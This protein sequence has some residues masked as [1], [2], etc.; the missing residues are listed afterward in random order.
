MLSNQALGVYQRVL[1]LD[2][3]AENSG[4]CK[5]HNLQVMLISLLHRS[6]LKSSCPW[7]LLEHRPLL[8]AWL[9][10]GK[11]WRCAWKTASAWLEFLIKKR[12]AD[13]VAFYALS[14]ITLWN[15]LQSPSSRSISLPLDQHTLVC[16]LFINHHFLTQIRSPPCSSLLM[17][18]RMLHN[19]FRS[20][21]E[22]NSLCFN[23]KFH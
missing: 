13:C 16:S 2:A 3:A 8:Q 17:S 18:C 20:L 23:C 22:R 1:P 4:E 7:A 12:G 19:S 15:S 11:T 9:L 6:D 21:K 10:G 14:L 5:W